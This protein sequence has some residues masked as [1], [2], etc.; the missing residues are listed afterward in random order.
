MQEHRRYEEL[1]A[2]AAVGQISVEELSELHAHMEDCDSCKDLQ[3]EFVEIN[4]L[5]LTQAQ[6]HEPEVYDS[7]TVLRKNILRKLESA[8]AEF[9]PAVRNEI[10][11]QP[12]RVKRFRFEHFQSP[13]RAL[14]VLAVV[15][16]SA[17]GFEVGSLRHFSSVPGKISAT[18]APTP[19]LPI[20]APDNNVLNR[21]A[22]SAALVA[23][24]RVEADLQQK[25]EAS[26][27][28]R[29]RLQSE[30]QRVTEQIVALQNA[31]NQDA[32]DLAQLR[33]TADQDHSAA[34]AAGAQLH[35]LQ[36]AQNSKDAALI[37]AQHHLRDLEGQ[38][39]QQTAA[40]ERE[41]ELAA[42][43]SSS[44]MEDVIGSRNLH[45]IDVADVDNNGVRK[46]FG[47]VFYTEGKSLIF[48]A[49][50]LA[51]I[52]GKQTFYAWGHKEGDPHAT[53][54]LGAL[55]KDSQGQERWVFRYSDTRVL[56]QI[57]SV[58]ITLEPNRPAGNKPKGERLLLAYL[59]T[60]PNHP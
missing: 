34:V 58:S 11:K 50:D 1:C 60:P 46:P 28:E 13:A 6:K 23:A 52:K 16:A 31:R 3:A 25:L 53:R 39:S 19:S 15:V 44:E 14:A 30:T 59:G 5:W 27:T 41:R 20:V 4:S 40:A 49:Y 22:D 38:L 47:R 36:E 45:I 43:A 57:D 7:Q 48:Y 29:I 33:A 42:L 9:S 10:V 26:E 18:A 8:G 21:R 51:N 2:Q 37:A 24:Q 56:A 17:L 32:S 12:E 54:V 35:T 55:V